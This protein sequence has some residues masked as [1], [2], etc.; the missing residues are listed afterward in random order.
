MSSRAIIF[1]L[2]LL[3]GIS[4]SALVANSAVPRFLS[5]KFNEV[6]ART[7]P[8]N[9]CP[10]DW[11]F[12]KKGEPVEV[13]A[14]FGHWRKIKD[15]K[16]EGGWVHSSGVSASRSAI[17][18]SQAKVQLLSS[19]HESSGAVAN[20]MPDL[21]CNLHK[22]IKEWCQISCKSYKGWVMRK[23]LWG[24]YPEEFQDK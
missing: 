8:E 21:R 23:Y 11:V 10:I 15:I 14:E 18:V 5:I 7:G 9:D 2:I 4:A 24:V 19:P 12:V 3:S 6:N 13:V 22:C 1:I 20:L 17:I 16:G